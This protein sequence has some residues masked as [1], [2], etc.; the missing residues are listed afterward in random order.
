MLTPTPFLRS[1]LFGK[2]VI[3]TVCIAEEW[4]T[5]VFHCDDTGKIADYKELECYRATTE[6]GAIGD[7]R[8]ALS[9]W[10]YR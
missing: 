9:R 5:M 3:S 1:V 6:Y 2:Y 7:H 10:M 8:V 4:E